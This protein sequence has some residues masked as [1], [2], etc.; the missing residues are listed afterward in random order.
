MTTEEWQML[1]AAAGRCDRTSPWLLRYFVRT[2]SSHV[3]EA[4]LPVGQTTVRQRC[5]NGV[6]TVS[7]SYPRDA[8]AGTDRNEDQKEKELHT[9]AKPALP[10]GMV[11]R[12]TEHLNAAAGTTYRP[13]GKKLRELVKARVND[14]ATEADFL[15]VIDK[16]VR[17]WKGTDMERYLR[18]L[19]LFGT[20][21]DEYLGQ[22]DVGPQGAQRSMFNGPTPQHKQQDYTPKKRDDGN[23]W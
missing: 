4:T 6:A 15:T 22:K 9:S 10:A 19:T 13:S 11:K 12:I 23:A 17:E 3:V 1:D 7:E 8:R 2:F 18:P 20:K 21:F 14:G 16:K 5:G